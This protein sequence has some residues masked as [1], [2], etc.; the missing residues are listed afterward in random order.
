MQ[1]AFDTNTILSAPGGAATYFLEL[2]PELLKLADAQD[3]LFVFSADESD[4]EPLPFLLRDEK[5]HGVN[6]PFGKG[7]LWRSLRFPAVERLLKNP[8]FEGTLDVC[9]SFHPPLMPSRAARRILSLHAIPGGETGLPGPTRSS[10]NQAEIVVTPSRSLADALLDALDAAPQARETLQAKLQVI[11]PAAHSR[12]SEPPTP[13]SVE[14]LCQRFPFLEQAYLLAVGAAADPQRSVPLLAQS[15]SR[16][17]AEDDSLPA[18]VFVAPEENVSTVADVLAETGDHDGRLL[19]MEEV[20]TEELPALYA[21]SEFLLHPGFGHTFGSSVLEA[22][23]L[24]ISAIVGSQAG[25][26]EVL[27]SSLTVPG[28]DTP[29]SWAAA[30]LDLHRDQDRKAE[31]IAEARTRARIQTW[32]DVAEAHWALYRG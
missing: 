13:A 28:H 15:Y 22:A 20:N 3:E 17:I 29:E 19:V 26:L 16:A 14:L 32:R 18:L 2:L 25:V 5:L 27:G 23:S 31:R 7:R 4:A 1:V 30:I 11:P 10:L 21:G 9:H 6:A 12:Y 24:G 8:E